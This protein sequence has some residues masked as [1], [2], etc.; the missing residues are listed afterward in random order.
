MKYL[1]IIAVAA[2]FFFFGRRSAQY[3]YNPVTEKIEAAQAYHK[4]KK[5]IIMFGDSHMARGV[6]ITLLNR[7]DVGSISFGG[8]TT[9]D[10]VKLTGDVLNARPEKCFIAVGVNDIETDVSR[11]DFI[12]NMDEILSAIGDKAKVYV[13]SIML[14][15]KGYKE[16][17]QFNS[18]VRMYNADLDSLCMARRIQV[19]NLNNIFAPDGYLS[20]EYTNDNIHLNESAFRLWATELAKYL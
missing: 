14:T 5:N 18:R 1:V 20:S 9:A 8:A 11:A 10:L 6:W 19:I 17:Q 4:R 2:I 16:A 15:G 3:V 12:N 13:H 7:C